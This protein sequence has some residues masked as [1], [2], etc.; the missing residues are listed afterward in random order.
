M[1]WRRKEDFKR[2][3]VFSLYDLHVYDHTLGQE[4]LPRGH[5]IYIL[6]DPS[7]VHIHLSQYYIL[8]YSNLWPGVK[9]KIFK[10]IKFHFMTYMAT[11]LHKNT[12]LRGHGIYNFG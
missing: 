8:S 4:P 5:E 12:C 10:E 7:V 11:P 6:E 1:P 9:M 2:N 3:N